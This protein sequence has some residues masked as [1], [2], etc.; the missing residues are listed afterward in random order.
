[1]SD[2]NC[3]APALAVDVVSNNATNRCKCKL[4]IS[5]E[6]ITVDVKDVRRPP[7]PVDQ[8]KPFRPQQGDEVEVRSDSDAEPG[9]ETAI[10]HPCWWIASVTIAKGEFYHVKYKGW[11]K[12]FD[13]IVEL[14]RL[15]PHSKE[16]GELMNIEKFM[17]PV[18][19]VLQQWV[20]NPDHL[21]EH[22]KEKCGAWGLALAKPKGKSGK[23]GD[24]GI[25]LMLLGTRSAYNKAEMLLKLHAKHQNGLKSLKDEA[26]QLEHTLQ[27]E[28]QKRGNSIVEEFAVDHDLI[29]MIVG[30]KGSNIRKAEMDSGVHSA[31]VEDDKVVIH[32]P[33]RESVAMCR[34]MLEMAKEEVEVSQKELG[35]IIGKR[36][37]NIRELMTETGVNRAEVLKNATPTIQLIGTQASVEKAKMWLQC[38]TEY[39][40]EMMQ[41]EADNNELRGELDRTALV[42]RRG[43][44]GYQGGS[45]GG[46][47]GKGGRGEARNETGDGGH[48]LPA[49]APRSELARSKEGA[50]KQTQPQPAKQEKSKPASAPKP[51]PKPKPD[52]APKPKAAA[53]P[54]PKVDAA[55]KPK[56]EKAG[57]PPVPKP[58]PNN[59]AP[60]S[61]AQIPKP[62]PGDAKPQRA[63][64]PRS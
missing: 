56:Q 42:Q 43:K 21:R 36:G 16:A 8:A 12:R 22:I 52:A 30:K 27:S 17:L 62:L 3:Y 15:R 55:P 38:H 31:V 28:R 54:K 51:A 61:S 11:E 58:K 35:W 59:P 9:G 2:K 23:K 48:D 24:Q 7:T 63:R 60:E 5:N 64:K 29:G 57:N 39:L 1:L 33:D 49:P 10:L 47:G 40:A 53:A 13:E 25:S 32:G 41:Q 6:E 50:S 44:G 46:Y 19:Q 45:Q 18:P 34:A 4:L 20:H 37:A 26:A 14:D